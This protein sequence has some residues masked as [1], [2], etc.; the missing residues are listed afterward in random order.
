MNASD[1]IAART[2]AVAATIDRIRAIEAGQGVSRASLD[3][4]KA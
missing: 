1:I 3:A 2:A 4:I